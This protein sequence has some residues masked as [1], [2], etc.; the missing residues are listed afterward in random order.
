MYE[1]IES[2]LKMCFTLDSKFKNQTN[3]YK[4]CHKVILLEK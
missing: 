2:V 1:F 4:I 3:S